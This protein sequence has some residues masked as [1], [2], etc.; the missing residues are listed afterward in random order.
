MSLAMTKDEREQFLADVHIGIVSVAEDGRAPLAVPVWYAYEPGGDVR[1][2]TGGDSR[3]IRALRTAGRASV[4]V[5]REAA[6][7]AYVTVE[8]P[9]TIEEA[10]FERDIKALAVRYLGERGAAN[11]LGDRS[12]AE[13][14]VL[15]RIRPERWLTVDYAKQGG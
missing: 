4:V 6:P 5:Q 11:Y 9:V 12:D 8:G 1:F 14:N 15:V 10:D 2:S 13:G 3:K 7:Y